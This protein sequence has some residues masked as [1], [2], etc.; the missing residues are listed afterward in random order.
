MSGYLWRAEEAKSEGNGAHQLWVKV[1]RHRLVPSAKPA[2]WWVSTELTLA[3]IRCMQHLAVL[4]EQLL[5]LLPGDT[6]ESELGTPGGH[7][8]VSRQGMEV[9][10]RPAP[11]VS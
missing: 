6:S 10:V 7:A 9:A 5:V 3:L 11:L 2:G 1:G 4:R 8:S